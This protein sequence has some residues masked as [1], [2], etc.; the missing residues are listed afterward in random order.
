LLAQETREPIWP[1]GIVG[2][3]SHDRVLS[4]AAAARAEAFAALGVDVEPDEPLDA[5]V[6]ARVWIP[7]EAT[8]ALESGVVPAASTA[9]LVFVAKE[10][11]YKCQFAL[12]RK[13]L[14]F[15]SVRVKLSPLTFEATLVVAVGPLARGT[16]FTGCWR[17]E[18]GELVATMAVQAPGLRGPSS[19]PNPASSRFSG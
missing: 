3:I 15:R 10:A 5:A 19:R 14:G 9:K 1:A 17:R 6:A 18:G 8:L 12:T 4:V 13:Y 11:F 16:R 2:T 7:E